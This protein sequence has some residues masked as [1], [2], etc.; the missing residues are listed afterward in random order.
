MREAEEKFSKAGEGV[1][2]RGRSRISGVCRK[3][4]GRSTRQRHVCTNWKNPFYFPRQGTVG[5]TGQ[6][7]TGT[8]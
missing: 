2:R 1:D 6:E 4:E 5:G 3:G 7:V 8:G